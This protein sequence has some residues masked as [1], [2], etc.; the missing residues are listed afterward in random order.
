[1]EVAL[2][3]L[4]TAIDWLGYAKNSMASLN[5]NRALYE[6]GRALFYMWKAADKLTEISS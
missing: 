1:M 5:M 6:I 2:D 3:D 4:Y